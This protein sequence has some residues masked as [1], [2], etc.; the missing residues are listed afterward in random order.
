MNHLAYLRF[1]LWDETKRGLE[2]PV[3]LHQAACGDWLGHGLNL[4]EG[5]LFQNV[6]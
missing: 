5:E 1:I 3:S 4:L 2:L 6:M